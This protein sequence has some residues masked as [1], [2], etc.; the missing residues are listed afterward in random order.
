MTH[1][2]RVRDVPLG[3]PTRPSWRGRLHLFG[4]MAALPT[5]VLLMVHAEGERATWGAAVYALGL[6]SMLT[7]S[8]VYHRWVHTI[9]ARR[10]W[11][12][13]DHATIFAAIAGT[14]TPL[15][16]IALGTRSGAVLIALVWAAAVIGAALK[17][18]G[19]PTADR[20]ASTMYIA[21]GWAGLLLIPA[22]WKIGGVTPVALLTVGGA[23]YTLGAVGFARQWPMLRPRVFS[24]HEVWHANTIAA[25]AAHF[26]AVWII[27]A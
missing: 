23:I 20:V 14:I 3:S 9:R 16:L 25:A 18:S 17:F 6:C 15:C 19:R 2:E 4:L 1:G 24:F 13:L 27:A 12:R 7:V 11:R 21:I 5:F 22:L 26:A 10:I 8:T